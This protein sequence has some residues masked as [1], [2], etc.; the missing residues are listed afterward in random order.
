MIS[1]VIK[2]IIYNFE[3][4][5][6]LYQQ[7]AELSCSQLSCLKEPSSSTRE[8]HRILDERQQLI[9]T[10]GTL[11]KANRHLQQVVVR[12]SN[13]EEFTL[14]QIQ[15]KIGTEEFKKLRTVVNRLGEI[16]LS[17]N[18]SD[19]QS[20]SLMAQSGTGLPGSRPANPARAVRAY[21]QSMQH[22]SEPRG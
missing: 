2:E 11:N 6:S 15:E 3:E 5:L 10:V 7:M 19:A 16:L 17:I 21:R 14:S 22:K 1:T 8:L 20:Q 13:L 4:Q 9:Q 18:E 12:E